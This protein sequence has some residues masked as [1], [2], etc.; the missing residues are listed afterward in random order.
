VE[1]SYQAQGRRELSYKTVIQRFIYQL[2]TRGLQSRVLQ[3]LLPEHVAVILDGNRRFAESMHSPSVSLGYQKGA[4]KVSELLDWCQDLRIPQVTIWVLSTDNL[5]RPPEQVQC[6][7]QV[8][9]EEIVKIAQGQER[10]GTPRSIRFFGQLESLSPSLCQTLDRVGKMTEEYQEYFLNIAI[11][12]GGREE[13]VHAVRGLL[14]K[15]EQEGVCLKEAAERVNAREIESHL[16]LKGLPEPELIIRTSGEVRLSGF[17]LWQSVY[18]EYYFCD[19]YWP[20]FRK[21]DF[22]RAIRS[23]Q[24]RKRRYGQ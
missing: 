4:Q 19:A 6:L 23:F 21:I 17:L 20:A 7:Y 8:I 13:I 14:G 15:Y 5:K 2:Y 12:Y 22:L 24:Q 1:I 9:E 18:S 3:G 10:S 11:A 16:Y